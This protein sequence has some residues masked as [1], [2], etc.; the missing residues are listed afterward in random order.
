[1][2]CIILF[3]FNENVARV[4][5]LYQG[6]DAASDIAKSSIE[7]LLKIEEKQSVNYI[8]SESK[9]NSVYYYFSIAE[10]IFK[11]KVIDEKCV[12]EIERV[13]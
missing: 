4:D 1:M 12:V 3:S 7:S 6:D 13:N 8:K 10:E 2:A 9:E 5:C 11:V